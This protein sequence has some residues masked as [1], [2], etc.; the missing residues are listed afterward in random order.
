[1]SKLNSLAVGRLI[2]QSRTK[3]I[4]VFTKRPIHRE[5]R[6]K[7]PNSRLTE[8]ATINLA[9][10]RRKK[11]SRKKEKRTGKRRG[12]ETHLGEKWCPDEEGDSQVI[13]VARPYVK[14]TDV[15]LTVPP[16][17]SPRSRQIP[18]LCLALHGSLSVFLPPA[19]WQTYLDEDRTNG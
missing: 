19:A 12:E 10:G 4:L 1:M 17:L 5:R 15:A 2:S 8:S 7:L 14:R 16:S 6:H 18:L 13:P 11:K 3:Y 9:T